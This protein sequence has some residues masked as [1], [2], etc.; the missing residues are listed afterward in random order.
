MKKLNLRKTRTPETRETLERFLCWPTLLQKWKNKKVLIWS[1]QWQLYWRSNK[2]GYTC[3]PFEA[4]IYDFDE[5][6]FAT[7]H[8]G[9]EK[10]IEFK[11]A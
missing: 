2:C 1:G 7:K 9:P 10:R 6:F 5:A 8:C 4:G 11:L 3:S